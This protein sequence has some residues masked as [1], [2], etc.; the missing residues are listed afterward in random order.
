MVD[1]RRQRLLLRRC[2][3]RCSLAI[4]LVVVIVIIILLQ[5]AR[6]R[7][8]TT[9]DAAASARLAATAIVIRAII[10]RAISTPTIAIGISKRAIG[11]GGSGSGGGSGGLRER[12]ELAELH[13]K[14]LKLGLGDFE[15]FGE[16]NELGR[17]IS[18]DNEG[19]QN[20]QKPV[21]EQRKEEANG[22]N[23][24]A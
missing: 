5:V 20:W 12:V 1:W 8:G 9:L 3:T 4:V 10:V 6:R 11:G 14:C 7:L 24:C 21:S 18:A 19:R 23:R 16:R 15:R 17:P 13:S 2:R 22:A